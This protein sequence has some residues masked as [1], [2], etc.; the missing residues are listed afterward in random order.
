MQRTNLRLLTVFSTLI[1]FTASAQSEFLGLPATSYIDNIA[2]FRLSG[3]EER[4]DIE[5]FWTTRIFSGTYSYAHVDGKKSRGIRQE[6]HAFVPEA[7]L[8]SGSGWILNVGGLYVHDSAREKSFFSTETEDDSY[9]ISIQPAYD[10]FHV[11]EREGRPE[12]LEQSRLIAGVAGAYGH[13]EG[14]LELHTWFFPPT[15]KYK[16]RADSYL[17]SPN[18]VFAQPFSDRLLALLIPAYTFTW[19]DSKIRGTSVDSHTAYHYFSLTGRGD[20]KVC[21]RL[22]A[23]VFATWTLDTHHSLGR[24]DRDWVEVGGQFH[25]ALNNR[26]GLRAG[27]SYEYYPDF[28]VNRCFAGLQAG[29]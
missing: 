20:Y 4:A 2:D 27:Y 8:E 18:L 3:D 5:R 16:T 14:D 19:S 28:R 1:T 6:S 7:Y 13:T 12:L 15:V 23:T 29:F 26:M 11:W 9:A 10:L 17:L 24:V 21:E 25:Y 22:V